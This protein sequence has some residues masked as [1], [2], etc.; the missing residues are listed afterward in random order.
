MRVAVGRARSARRPARCSLGGD[1]GPVV[2]DAPRRLVAV[3][4]SHARPRPSTRPARG[5]RRC[6]PG[7]RPPGAPWP[8]RARQAPCRRPVE[9][10]LDVR[11]P[12]R[13]TR[14]SSTTRADDRR[15]GRPADG[16]CVRA[17][18]AG[19]DQQVVD[20]R[21]QPR[22]RRPRALEPVAGRARASGPGG[23]AARRRWSSS[24]ASGVR[25]SWLVSSI[26]RRCASA[27][28]SS[29]SSIAS[30]LG[31]QRRPP[32]S[33]P[34]AGRCAGSGPTPRSPRPPRA[35]GRSG[36]PRGP[37]TTT[38]APAAT[39]A[40]AIDGPRRPRRRGRSEPCGDD[41][42]AADASAAIS[43]L[44]DHGRRRTAAAPGT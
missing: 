20:R 34:R 23:R 28:R 30:K 37:P 32:R 36:A 10:Q 13:S 24:T 35:P 26:S 33:G 39:G 21:L 43:L 42:G 25:S 1:A 2:G 22:G 17:R 44:G 27:A 16:R 38:P 5:G 6:R 11:P 8:R 29:R 18:P 31:G 41:L 9:R 40:R 3:V 4:G 14:A 15:R 19:I 12:R 7:W